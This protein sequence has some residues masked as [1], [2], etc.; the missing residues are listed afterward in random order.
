MTSVLLP[1]PDTPVTQIMVLSGKSTSTFWRLLARA[2][3]IPTLHPL[4]RRRCAGTGISS[5]PDR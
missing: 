4:P 1:E 5:A 2:P 3:R